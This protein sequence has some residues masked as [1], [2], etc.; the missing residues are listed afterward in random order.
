MLFGRRFSIL[1]K[2]FQNPALVVRAPGMKRRC[3]KE[4]KK[5]V[6]RQDYN[7]ERRDI[8]DNAL[9]DINQCREA[10]RNVLKLRRLPS[11]SERQTFRNARKLSAEI[12]R[13]RDQQLSREF[14]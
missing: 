5:G 13:V 11:S 10:E 9:T 14:R 4:F 7:L 1:N 3:R 2:N 6:S 12:L 8:L